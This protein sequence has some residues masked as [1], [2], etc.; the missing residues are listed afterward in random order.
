MIDEMFYDG[1][2]DGVS[3]GAVGLIVR[4][5]KAEFIGSSHEAGCFAGGDETG[6]PLALVVEDEELTAAA[7]FG[8]AEAAGGVVEAEFEGLFA[9][10]GSPV[11]G[12][13]SAL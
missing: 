4:R 9:F 5:G 13:D 7:A 11:A 2:D 1:D 10:A 8:G 6:I 12:E 3:H